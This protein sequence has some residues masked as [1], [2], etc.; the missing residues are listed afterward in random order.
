MTEIRE[1]GIEKEMFLLDKNA[2]IMEPRLYG[3][4]IDEFE[5]LVE[6]RS[7]PSDEFN[8]KKPKESPVFISLMN[9]EDN[10]KLRAN[11]FGMKL[12]D[13]PSMTVENYWIGN[14]WDKYNLYE[15]IDN[16]Y[17]KNIYKPSPKHKSH[18]IGVMNST[19]DGYR[20]LTAGMHVHFSSRDSH[21]GEV[22][23]LPIEKIVK[24]MDR[25]FS[26]EIYNTYRNKGEW[27]LKAHG[28]EYR[29][30]P[31]NCDVYKVLKE[32]FKI[33]RDV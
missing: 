2:D 9:E 27:E 10:Y 17:T 1:I 18:H 26:D 11:K 5:F 29:S 20:I 15:L 23:D 3:F 30:L 25:K 21:T 13:K 31:C 19:V 8:T 22:I 28:F 24:S 16:D 33:L 7:L 6:L 4:P 32:S 14:L 12:S